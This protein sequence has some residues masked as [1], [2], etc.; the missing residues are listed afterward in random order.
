MN[1]FC[2][3]KRSFRVFGHSVAIAIEALILYVVIGFFV[4]FIE[5]K[6]VQN[7][8]QDITVYVMS[9]GVH[10]D[11]VLPIRNSV[12]DWSQQIAF[13]HTKGKDT[14]ANYIAFGWGDKGFY[15]NTPTWADLKFST[16]FKAVFGLSETAIH[17]TFYKDIVENEKCVKLKI[18]ESNY[19]RLVYYIEASFKR[20]EKG[21]IMHIATNA[22]YGNSDA[23]YEA[24]GTYNLF[25]TC[26]TWANNG[27]KAS[28]QKASLW[29]L[30][31]SGI[32]YHYRNEI[33]ASSTP[34]LV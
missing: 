24:V 7:Q 6:A 25:Q 8:E 14:T 29:T 1:E 18:S 13:Q 28:A 20:D 31:D 19:R 23:F 10:T 26:N 16:A 30:L 22:V 3:M 9:N 34:K 17:T 21:D 11:L 32:F 33:A 15:L 5:V 2:T 27:L 12:K 4:A